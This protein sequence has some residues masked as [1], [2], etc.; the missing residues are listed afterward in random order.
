[1]RILT[2]VQP[3]G[4]LHLGNYFSAIHK[5]LNYQEKADL[6]LFIANLH[7]ITTFSSKENL[8]E[9][10]ISAALDLLALGVNPEK[11]IFW[12]QS[13]IPEVTELSWYLSGSITVS[14]LQLA[15]SF[16]DKVAKGFTPGA[17]LFTYP[18][19]MAADIL[20]F[21]S[22]K[23]PVGKDQKQ[24][25]EI[26]R[27]IAE[28]FNA[29]FGNILTIPEPDIDESTATIPGVDGAKMSKSYKNTIDLFGTEKEIKKAVMSIVSDSKEIAEP[30]NPDES[31]IFQIHKLFLNEKETS[32]LRNRYL[33]GGVGYGDLKKS[34]LETV[35][36]HFAPFRKKRED[37]QNDLGYVNSVLNS[38]KEKAKSIAEKKIKEV[39]DALGIYPFSIK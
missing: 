9:N 2:G 29:Q 22:E 19:L 35:M 32:E 28:R 18:I 5:I 27:D 30:K 4:K 25:L 12:V 6:L 10:T 1:M 31:V 36:D 23:V 8:K 26:T 24:H 7:A 33:A 38:G 11:T 15:H 37:L 14:Q 16:K 3:S 20:L 39:R 34:L 21:S 17:G 13:E